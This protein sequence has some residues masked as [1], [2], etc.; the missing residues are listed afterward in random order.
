MSGNKWSRK[1]INFLKKNWGIINCSEI[2]SKLNRTE[3]SVYW[4]A[5]KLDLRV[6]D[7]QGVSCREAEEISGFNKGTILKAMID[8]RISKGE[9]KRTS[10]YKIKKI[11]ESLMKYENMNSVCNRH[12]LTKYELNKVIDYCKVK[13][14]SSSRIMKLKSDEIDEAIKKYNR[15]FKKQ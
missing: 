10:P 9:W 14:Y 5:S 11:V 15:I 6:K 2:S 3:N 12:G 1:E 8:N 7:R 4:K 13:N